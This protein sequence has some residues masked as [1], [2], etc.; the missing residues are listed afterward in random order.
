M[1]VA[2]FL[3][4]SLKYDMTM[5]LSGFKSDLI[6]VLKDETDITSV[7]EIPLNGNCTSVIIFE[8]SGLI[9]CSPF[10]KYSDE[11]FVLGP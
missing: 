3:Q 5:R 8:A 4:H 10:Q 9:H 11:H 6:K 2:L 1:N 7:L